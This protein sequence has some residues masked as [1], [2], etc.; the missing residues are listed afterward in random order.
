MDRAL[1]I[2]VT[3][4]LAS[5]GCGHLKIARQALEQRGCIDIQLDEARGTIH[6]TARCGQLSCTGTMVVRGTRINYTID[7]HQS[8][9]SW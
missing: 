1:F 2:V 9:G 5:S 6:Y 4:A 3:L 8:C 7:D